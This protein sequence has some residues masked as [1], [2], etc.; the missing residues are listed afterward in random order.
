MKFT[1]I[2]NNPYHWAICHFSE[3]AWTVRS[4]RKTPIASIVRP[5]ALNAAIAIE[6]PST[7]ERQSSAE[8]EINSSR[9]RNGLDLN[10]IFCP[11]I[12]HPYSFLV[13][14]NVVI[15]LTGKYLDLMKYCQRAI[16]QLKPSKVTFGWSKYNINIMHN[17]S[18]LVHTKHDAS[19]NLV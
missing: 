18:A 15:S 5:Q 6:A 1:D 11:A 2:L 16:A 14:V 9:W 13:S 17:E 4:F 7:I 3:S 10:I 19:E 12:C 8:C